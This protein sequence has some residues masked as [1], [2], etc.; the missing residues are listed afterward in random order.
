MLAVVLSL[1]VALVASQSS[2]DLQ[3][4]VYLIQ[5]DGSL[6]NYDGSVDL[7]GP[8]DGE[9]AHTSLAP[10]TNTTI[11]AGI[12]SLGLTQ[13]PS[14]YTIDLVGTS[15]LPEQCNSFDSSTSF[16]LFSGNSYEMV[17]CL[18][19][20]QGFSGVVE[21]VAWNDSNANG[22]RED[23]EHLLSGVQV[24]LFENGLTVESVLTDS[25]GQY[26]FQY[27]SCED[28]RLTVSFNR[29]SGWTFSPAFAGSDRSRNSDVIDAA[30]STIPFVPTNLLQS[31]YNLDAGYIPPKD[32]EPQCSCVDCY[33][34]TEIRRQW[35]GG[36]VEQAQV[37]QRV[38]TLSA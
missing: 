32:A 37:T 3:V 21:G 8:Q 16:V 33:D 11:E 2:V 25:M 15:D 38:T 26:H 35:A 7:F 18:V 20:T 27:R 30:G 29:P 12:Y 24:T 9:A 1:L 31:N 34:R 6:I 22:I 5:C 36:Y 28:P 10:F 4:D 17:Y 14:G 19:P 23:A 13:V